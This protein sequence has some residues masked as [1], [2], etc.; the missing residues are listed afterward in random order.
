M[1][2]NKKHK[3]FLPPFEVKESMSIQAAGDRPGWNITAF[4]LPKAWEKTQGEGV[5]VYVLDT[6]ADL[7]HPDLKPNLIRGRNFINDKTDPWDDNMHGSHC[8]G[9]IC[10][11]ENG[12]GIIGVAP[13][14]NVA[15][16]KVLG[17]NGSGDMLVVAEA[18][19]WAVD[20][21]AD[22]ISMS[23]G[24][25]FKVTQV[26]RAVQYAASKNVP[27]F[28]AAGNN[29]ITK[30]VFYPSRYPETISIGSIDEN[31]KRSDFSNTGPNLDFMAPGGAILS[32]V[33]DNWYSVLSGTSMACPFAVGVAALLLSYVRNNNTGMK[34]ETVEDYRVQFQKHTSQTTDYANNDFF[35]GFGIIDPRK[36]YEWLLSQDDV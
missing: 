13:K 16:V 6:G 31:F 4:D 34:L 12:Q 35:Q 9:I 33:P 17:A 32:T 26:R 28:C 27:I 1:T 24:S 23:L 20:D 25:P 15:P 10:S 21:G 29:G 36:F 18:I 22:L 30:D 8:A 19:R 2:K 14:S 7:D 5:K 3:C 11:P